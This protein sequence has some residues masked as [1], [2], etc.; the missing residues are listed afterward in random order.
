MK[1]REKKQKSILQNQENKQCYLC[2]LQEGNYAYQTVE[3]H[4]IFFGP[5]RRNSELYGF[6]GKSLHT[7]SQNRKRSS[8][9]ESGE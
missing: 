7:T 5:N 8:A 9:F 1:K 3:D 6:N 4:H 2:M